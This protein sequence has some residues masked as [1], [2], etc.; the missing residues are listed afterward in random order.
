MRNS[1]FLHA[2]DRPF[3]WLLRVAP[4]EVLGELRSAAADLRR[5]PGLRSF[6]LALAIAFAVV[7]A[8]HVTQALGAHRDAEPFE[9]L[10][11]A[12]YWRLD[13]DR[14]VP[15]HLEYALLLGAAAVMVLCWRRTGAPIYAVLAIADVYIFADNY[16]LIHETS[17]E[18]MAPKTPWRGELL[19]F[20]SIGLA[21]G[22]L[23]IFALRQSSAPDRAAGGLILVALAGLAGCAVFVD[24]LHSIAK[25]NTDS[26]WLKHGLALAEDGGELAFIML[27]ALASVVVLRRI[28]ARDADPARTASD[29]PRSGASVGRASARTSGGDPR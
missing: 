19:F 13:A 23:V 29:R 24:M 8:V 25:F 10:W 27:N 3:A 14:S 26:N 9:S 2:V 7:V 1:A 16:L 21:L 12:G 11:K 5:T 18:Q 28:G 6:A 4:S 20:T 15:E 17:G 22:A